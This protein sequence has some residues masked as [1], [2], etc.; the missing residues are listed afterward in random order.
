[1]T[2][3]D[4]VKPPLSAEFPENGTALPVAFGDIFR[5][6]AYADASSLEL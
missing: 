2:V 5:L 3:Q 6:R 1:L 4:Q